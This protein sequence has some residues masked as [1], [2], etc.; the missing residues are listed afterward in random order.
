M[1]VSMLYKVARKLLSFPKLLLRRDTA[2]DAE[3]LVL[4]HENGPPAT[5]YHPTPTSR[6]LPWTTSRAADSCAPAFS[7]VS[8]TSTDT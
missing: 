1:I 5:S 7:A 2:K 4:R 8:S 6:P 3:L